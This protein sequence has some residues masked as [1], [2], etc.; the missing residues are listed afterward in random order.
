MN[1]RPREAPAAA[2]RRILAGCECVMAV[3]AHDPMLGSAK[4]EELYGLREF[5]RPGTLTKVMALLAGT[6]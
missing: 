2:L 1:D 6:A 5:D 4:A 3:S